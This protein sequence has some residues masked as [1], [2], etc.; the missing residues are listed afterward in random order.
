MIH[1]YIVHLF[2]TYVVLHSVAKLSC[3]KHRM[4]NEQTSKRDTKEYLCSN[5]KNLFQ[6]LRNISVEFK[7]NPLVLRA[8]VVRNQG[9]IDVRDIALYAKDIR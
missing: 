5:F 9:Y 6:F 7:S 3:K 1:L 8:P 4:L 2:V